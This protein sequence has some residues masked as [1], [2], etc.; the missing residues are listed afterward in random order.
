M[1]AV[2]EDDEAGSS[3]EVV[4]YCLGDRTARRL[5]DDEHRREHVPDQRWIRKRCQVYQPDTIVELVDDLPAELQGEARLPASTGTRNRQQAPLA[6]SLLDLRQILL[7]SDEA[8]R[9]KREVVPG[10]IARNELHR[11]SA[12]ATAR[13]GLRSRLEADFI[14]TGQLQCAA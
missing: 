13:R 1:L 6:E 3:A 9:L 14:L 10:V 7:L 8:R 4:G 2:I 11:N 5:W 12:R